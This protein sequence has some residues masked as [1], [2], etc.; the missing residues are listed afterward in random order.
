MATTTSTWGLSLMPCAPITSHVSASLI[1]SESL[2][3]IILS[4]NMWAD[5]FP[6]EYHTLIQ[7]FHSDP[8][9]LS[10]HELEDIVLSESDPL[11]Q[12]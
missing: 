4:R 5:H 8:Y 2:H 10:K 1:Q 11:L 3:D 6:Y 7:R 9:N 12:V